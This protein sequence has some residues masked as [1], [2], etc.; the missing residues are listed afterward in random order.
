MYLEK[1]KFKGTW[2][3]YQ[4]EVLSELNKH[5][6]DKKIN[7]VAAPGSGK[8]ILGL[9][10]IRR[11]N[12]H[13]LILTPTITIRNQW[14]ERFWNMYASDGEKIDFISQDI[15]NINKFN[16]VTYQALHYALNKKKIQDEQNRA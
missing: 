11:L 15:Y 5:L 9:E 14:E 7:I 16:I 4:E 10:I 3:K 2:R 6:K 13:V 8:T 1:C 12:E